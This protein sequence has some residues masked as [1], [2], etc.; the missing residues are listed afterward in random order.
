M[1]DLQ[2]LER[3]IAALGSGETTEFDYPDTG[4]D[5]SAGSWMTG[6]VASAMPTGAPTALE[7]SDQPDAIRHDSVFWC[8]SRFVC[9]SMHCGGSGWC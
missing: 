6:V 1:S 4:R 2:T 9:A 8:E 3:T 5:G 7:L